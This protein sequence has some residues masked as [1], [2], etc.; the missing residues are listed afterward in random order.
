MVGVN[1]INAF[2]ILS[3]Q[4]NKVCVFSY[5]L[6]RKSKIV[7]RQVKTVHVAVPTSGAISFA[8]VLSFKQ[9][10]VENHQ[11][12]LVRAQFFWIKCVANRLVKFAFY[13]GF[14]G[15]VFDIS[16]S[17]SIGD[18][19]RCIISSWWSNSR[20]IASFGSYSSSAFLRIRYSP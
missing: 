20:I 16:S 3:E 11:I 17:S 8:F 7:L 19:L 6:T 13:I 14:A 1:V 15:L 4:A 18:R 9:Q 12:L 5:S 10:V 2:Q